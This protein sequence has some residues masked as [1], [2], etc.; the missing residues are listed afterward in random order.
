MPRSHPAGQRQRRPKPTPPKP[1][2]T[3]L[4]Y[5]V[6]QEKD[7]QTSSDVK[8]LRLNQWLASTGLCSRRKADE[9]IEAGRVAING[10]KVTNFSTR[11]HPV[12][13]E[14][15]V[16]GRPVKR[17]RQTGLILFYKPNGLLTTK[18]DEKG[19]KTIYD[20]LPDEFQ[21][22][23]PA[24]RLDRNSHGLLLMSN[25]GVLL[26]RLTHPSFNVHKRYIATVNRPIEDAESVANTLLNGVF[27]EEEQVTATVDEVALLADDQLELKLTTGYN[28]QI[29]RMLEHCGYEVKQLKRIS[30]GSFK[31]SGLRPGQCK[32]VSFR[33]LTQLK[34]QLKL[35]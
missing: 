29:R 17:H 22:Y 24:G 20:V 21:H 27:L 4:D 6:K 3:K 28:R 14:V 35:L 7:G 8:Q 5:K 33:E 19:R 9:W 11:V 10:K 2:V 32:P 25:D 18:K 13:D 12:R 34:K 30:V 1:E 15:K 23:K 31:L 16:D 26:N